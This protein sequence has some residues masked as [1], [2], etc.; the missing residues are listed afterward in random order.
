MNW[1]AADLVVG[2]EQGLGEQVANVA[3]PQAVHHSPPITPT[4]NQA[5]K[6]ELGEVLAGNGRAASSSLS[7]SGHVG[8]TCP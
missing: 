3:A 1:F 2:V 8:F 7:Q 6:A 5:S 4:L